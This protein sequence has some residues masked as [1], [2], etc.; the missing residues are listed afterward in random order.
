YACPG[1]YPP[2]FNQPTQGFFTTQ[3][4]D[5]TQNPPVPLLAGEGNR[6]DIWRSV[7]GG[8]TWQSVRVTGNLPVPMNGEMGRINLT[9]AAPGAA[10]NAT[11]VYA[12][13]GTQNGSNTVAVMRS[14][15]S[16]QTWTIVSQGANTVPTNPAPGATRG[17]C[18]TM[19][20]GHGQS[21]YDL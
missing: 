5:F 3:C 17:D 13:G 18:L 4:N 21:Q 1:T 19:D 9:A 20:I 10:P 12:L 2:S 11:T 8:A 15:D 7:D 6:G 14:F 16:G